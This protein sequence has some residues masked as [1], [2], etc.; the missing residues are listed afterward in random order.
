V[1]YI[2]GAQPQLAYDLYRERAD[3][4]GERELLVPGQGT[5]ESGI[6]E[7]VLAA[8]GWLALRLGTI[9]LD[10]DVDLAALLLGQDSVPAELPTSG[11]ND[12]A[13]SISPDGRW[14]AHESDETGR[15]EVYVRSFPDVT[16]RKEQISADG[17]SMPVWS[18]SGR[19]LFYVNGE[20]EMVAVNVTR[21]GDLT[22]GESRVL[23]P[24]PEGTLFTENEYYALYDV[25]V[26][27]QRFLM[28]TADGEDRASRL[29][30]V[31][32][33]LG[34]ALETLGN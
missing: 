27:D 5:T 24:L 4:L 34:E 13:I 26:D 8:N 28:M 22:V 11:F 19:E 23:F 33:W 21:G 10:S 31:F 12:R 30:V 32:N 7:G 18:R 14:M 25:D 15:T 17:G 29:V 6:L 20:R 16:Q 1:T 3:G 2:S 9:A